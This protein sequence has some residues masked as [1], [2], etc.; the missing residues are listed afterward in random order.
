M[1]LIPE[2]IT[3][4][5]AK[6]ASAT[7]SAAQVEFAES[8]RVDAGAGVYTSTSLYTSASFI[9]NLGQAFSRFRI[10]PPMTPPREEPPRPAMT[11]TWPISARQR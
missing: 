11:L 3:D 1:K 7:G 5:V 6:V 9:Q 2:K 8:T 10:P 4:E